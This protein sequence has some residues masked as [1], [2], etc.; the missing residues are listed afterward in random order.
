MR[1]MVPL[2]LALVGILLLAGLFGCQ[3]TTPQPAAGSSEKISLPVNF[4]SDF[5]IYNGAKLLVGR[6]DLDSGG[7]PL[8]LAGWSTKDDYSK[9]AAFYNQNL[10]AK[11]WLITKKTQPNANMKQYQ[12]KKSTGLLRGILKIFKDPK[13]GETGFSVSITDKSN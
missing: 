4:P 7:N 2:T 10:V 6:Q 1:K 11:G 5:P 12:F 8:Y 13:T 3:K 9:V